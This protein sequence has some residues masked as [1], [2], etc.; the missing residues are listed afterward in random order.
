MESGMPKHWTHTDRGF[1]GVGDMKTTQ[2]LWAFMVFFFSDF[3]GSSFGNNVSLLV[4]DL[5]RARRQ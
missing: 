3:S 1:P 5:R 4:K 2:V